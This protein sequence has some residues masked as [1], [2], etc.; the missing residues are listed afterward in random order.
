MSNYKYDV[1]RYVDAAWETTDAYL[2]S[3]FIKDDEALEAALASHKVEGL[4]AINVSPL[5]GTMLFQMATMQSQ[6]GTK[7]ISILEVGTLAG[8]ETLQ[9]FFWRY[10]RANSG[11]GH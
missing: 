6:A 9:V 5:Q 2:S 7:P 4:P 1:E 11:H 8:C 3:L 10:S